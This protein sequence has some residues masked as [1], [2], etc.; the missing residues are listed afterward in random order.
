VKLVF[1]S[2]STFLCAEHG[3][4]V[5]SLMRLIHIIW[6]MI[7]YLS[8][9]PSKP[10]DD[11]QRLAQ[12]Y[13]YSWCVCRYWCA[14]WVK[15]KTFRCSLFST[16]FVEAC[17]WMPIKQYWGDFGNERVICLQYCSVVS[18]LTSF[19]SNCV[20]LCALYQVYA[21]FLCLSTDRCKKE[22]IKLT[23][24]INYVNLLGILIIDNMN[25]RL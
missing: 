18:I 17:F 12:S 4:I 15:L 25:Y 23:I 6:R 20:F 13:L 24:T 8:S 9:W 11:G 10:I 1:G 16:P 19:S 5:W 3:G 14:R 21:L 2:A 7:T 22:K